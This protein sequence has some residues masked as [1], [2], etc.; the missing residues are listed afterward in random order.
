MR[1]GG[2]QGLP[3]LLLSEN[4]SPFLFISDYLQPPPPLLAAFSTHVLHI[5]E[6]VGSRKVC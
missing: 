1:S 6:C 4:R 5:R 2:C 3:S